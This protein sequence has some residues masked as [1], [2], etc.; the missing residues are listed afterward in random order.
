M[1]KKILS[2]TTEKQKQRRNQ[3]LVGGILIFVMLFS[4]LGY[5]FQG[6][7]NSSSSST[8]TYNGVEFTS[9][10]GYWYLEKNGAEFIFRM[11]PANIKNP[12]GEINAISNYYSK[13]LYL[14][15]EDSLANSQIYAN[16]NSIILRIQFACEENKSCEEDIPTKSCE[17]NFIIIEEANESTITQIE[18]CV[19]IR[20]PKEKLVEL[21]DSFILKILGIN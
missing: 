4:T 16:L 13:V 8:I 18:N 21:T 14:S 9:Q 1:R 20:G 12:E 11:N 7:D 19:Y 2:K 10:N 17:S 15:S 6:Q 5:A 3:L